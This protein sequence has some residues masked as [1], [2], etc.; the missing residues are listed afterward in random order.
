[1]TEFASDLHQP[2]QFYAP[3]FSN[4]LKPMRSPPRY[5][6]NHRCDRVD[7][8]QP[9][10]RRCAGL[11]VIGSRCKH[12]LAR[13]PTRVPA[14]ELKPCR[15]SR[16]VERARD[17]PPTGEQGKLDEIS[18]ANHLRI[19]SR[20]IFGEPALGE[21]IP[22]RACVLCHSAE[23]LGKCT[24]MSYIEWLPQDSRMCPRRT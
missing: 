3:R 22:S 11:A 10:G 16:R 23:I 15:Q 18:S 17:G 13:Q 12:P 8:S 6:P 21:T 20:S 14:T 2:L 19:G 1:L 4:F 7:S 9:I 24:G 5:V